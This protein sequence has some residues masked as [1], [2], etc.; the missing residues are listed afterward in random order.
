MDRLLLLA[1]RLS[2]LGG[3]A[4][5]VIAGAARVSGNF[6]ILGFQVGTLLQAGIGALVV[7]CFLLLWVLTGRN[8]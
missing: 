1:G 6:W 4:L 8:S 2:G 7:G 3:L 5:C